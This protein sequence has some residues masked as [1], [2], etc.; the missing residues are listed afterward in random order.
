[1]HEDTLED[2][3]ALLREYTALCI[4]SSETE[5]YPLLKAI[6]ER[7]KQLQERLFACGL[8]IKSDEGKEC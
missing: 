3:G 2:T 4:L 6:A 8:P 1:M 5:H 7:R